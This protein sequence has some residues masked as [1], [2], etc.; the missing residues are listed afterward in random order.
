MR[1]WLRLAEEE[2]EVRGGGGGRIEEDGYFLLSGLK[3][4]VGYWP[5]MAFNPL[6]QYC[7]ITCAAGMCGM[8]CQS[9]LESQAILSSLFGHLAFEPWHLLV[10]DHARSSVCSV[11][12]GSWALFG[13][14][15]VSI[16]SHFTNLHLALHSVWC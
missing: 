3:G 4:L 13:N 10:T 1:R 8:C 15:F 12:S 2:K 14:T 7:E 11:E 9:S 16:Q 6:Y 5:P